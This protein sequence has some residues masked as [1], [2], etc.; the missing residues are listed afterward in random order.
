MPYLVALFAIVFA[1]SPFLTPGFGGFDPDQ[2]PIPQINPP[3]QPAGYAFGIWGV[4]YV[5]LIIGTLFGAWQ[6]RDDPQW[7]GMRPPLLISLI[8]GAAWLPVALASPV[9]A[10]LL[11]WFM[12]ASACVALIRAPL[13]DLSLIHI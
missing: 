12:W 10:T 4:I 13:K 8:V 3:V 5:W 1:L 7:Q 6:R 9:W 11:I 2:F